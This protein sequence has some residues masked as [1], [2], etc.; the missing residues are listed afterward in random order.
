MTAGKLRAFYLNKRKDQ[1]Q[2]P[3]QR[4][5]MQKKRIFLQKNHLTELTKPHKKKK[6]KNQQTK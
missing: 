2:K 4:N 5:K 1:A 6:N 3:E